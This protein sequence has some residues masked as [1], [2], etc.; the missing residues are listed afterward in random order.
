MEEEAIELHPD[1]ALVELKEAVVEALLVIVI[2]NVVHA[3][4][5]GFLLPLTLGHDA[6][7]DEQVLCW[8][9]AG[10]GSYLEL[11]NIFYDPVFD[12]HC[13]Q[14]PKELRCLFFQVQVAYIV[15]IALARFAILQL[16]KC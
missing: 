4:D 15:E 9:V 10:L 7:D 3:D 16:D 8:S 6:H 2:L 11:S 1:F 14:L 5:H 12:C 13:H